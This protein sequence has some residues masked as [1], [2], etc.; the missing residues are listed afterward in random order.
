[1]FDFSKIYDKINWRNKPDKT[2]PIDATNL[3][4]IDAALNTIDDRV[5]ELGKKANDTDDAINELNS[6]LT[7][8][9]TDFT[10]QSVDGVTFTGSNN[11][12]HNYYVATLTIT[13]N[14]TKIISTWTTIGTVLKP[15][16]QTVYLGDALSETES[17]IQILN[18][19][20]IQ[21]RAQKE[22]S[23]GLRTGSITYVV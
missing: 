1:M 20:S 11:F 7:A 16:K 18:N 5:V 4:K 3:G 2:T 13:I 23:L 19:G 9:K 12:S 14:V 10:K 21:V 17:N 22:S 8:I 15:P 6:N